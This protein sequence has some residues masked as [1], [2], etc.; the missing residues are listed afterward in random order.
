MLDQ[1][2]QIDIASIEKQIIE[3]L[4]PQIKK[5]TEIILFETMPKLLVEEKEFKK[6]ND[7]VRKDRK[8]RWQKALSKHNSDKVKAYMDSEF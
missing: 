4:Q 6:V 8:E 7:W 3:D 5:Q 1:T 2:T